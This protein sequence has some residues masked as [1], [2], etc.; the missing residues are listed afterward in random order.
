M[1]SWYRRSAVT[2]IHLA[3][4]FA[5]SSL[6]ALSSSAWFKRGWTLQE[7]LAARTVLFYTNDW[8]L[9]MDS[10]ALNHKEVPAI[11]QEVGRAAGIDSRYLTDFY[12]GVDDPRSKLCWASSRRTTRVEDIA[13]SLFGIFDIHLPVLYGEGKEKAVGRLLQEIISQSGNTSVL[14]WVGIASSFHSCFPTNI[15]YYRATPRVRPAMTEVAIQRSLS[16]L[17]RVVP[18]DTAHGLYDSLANLPLPRFANRRLT[19][20]CIIH[21]VHA[22]RLKRQHV[23]AYVYEI[24]ATGLRSLE[25]TSPTELKEWSMEKLLPYVLVRVWDRKL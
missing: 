17:Q 5:H 19:L 4:V 14:D 13:Y 15:T 8:S 18:S 20:P 10:A 25:V 11:L 22:V 7:L 2:I 3:D 16:R 24:Q 9:Y 1:F 21:S 23:S 6:V 12:P